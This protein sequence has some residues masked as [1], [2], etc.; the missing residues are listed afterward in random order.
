MTQ[1]PPPDRDPGADPD[2]DGG[3]PG[4]GELRDRRPVGPGPA[5]G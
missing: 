2:R 4:D 3:L 5:D 1:P